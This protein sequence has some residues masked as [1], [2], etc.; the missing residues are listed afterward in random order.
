[1]SH[2]SERLVDVP[3]LSLE[4]VVAHAQL[5]K[6]RGLRLVAMTAV[7]R[8][9]RSVDVLYHFGRDLVLEHSRLTVAKGAT[10]PS[11]SGVFF[12]A[13]L[14]EN[15]IQDQ[16]GLTF[17]GLVLDYHRTLLLDGDVTEVPFMSSVKI[18][19]ARSS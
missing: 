16:F 7:E 18:P 15:E 19:P 9:E 2:G 4:G 10:V 11:I 12:A 3:V 8:D 5:V 17:D 6:D 14:V 1:M 13:L